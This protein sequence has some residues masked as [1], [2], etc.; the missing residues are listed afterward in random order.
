MLGGNHLKI[1]CTFVMMIIHYL[2]I[3]AKNSQLLIADRLSQL[4]EHQTRGCEF[5]Y[6]WTDMKGLEIHVTEEKVVPL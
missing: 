1:T 2:C 4:L 3:R 5:D 6:G